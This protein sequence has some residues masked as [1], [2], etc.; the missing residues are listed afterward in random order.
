MIITTPA[1]NAV[2]TIAASASWPP[3]TFVSDVFDPHMWKWTLTWDS[4]SA[5]GTASTPAGSWDA[6]AVVT[7]RGGT[8]TVTA[9]AGTASA[10]TTVRIVGTNPTK[11]DV[12]A[13]LSAKA[14]SDGLD[15]IIDHETKFIH[16]TNSHEPSKSFDNGY[17]M[18]QLTN[19]KPTLEQAWNWKMNVDAGLALFADKRKAARTYLGQGGRPFTDVQLR[20]EAICRWNG[21]AY[22]RGDA[23]AGK[24]IR[25][26]NVLCDTTTGNIGWDMT[27]A[28]N[29]GKTAAQLRARDSASYKHPPAPTA[30]WKYF[31]ICYADS[32]LGH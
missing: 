10:S 1:T 2:F 23:G 24:W 30:H 21:G 29:I 18:C 32:V 11:A 26:P 5:S 22:H 15:R 25:S 8:L 4:Y 20:L 9:T 7:N 16:F 28:E 6:T 19:P 27:D 17:G 3:L 12:V 13:Y 14:D 31:G